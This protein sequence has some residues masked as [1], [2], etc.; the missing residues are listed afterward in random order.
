MHI[1][2]PVKLKEVRDILKDPGFEIPE[3]ALYQFCNKFSYT[4]TFTKEDL[5]LENTDHLN[6]TFEIDAKNPSKENK[7]F[8]N[9]QVQF[10]I[11]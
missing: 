5:L 3:N 6:F 9:L 10:M 1:V 4:F 2:T 7:K 11:Y 8:L